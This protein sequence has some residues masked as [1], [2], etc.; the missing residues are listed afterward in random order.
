MGRAKSDDIKV[1]QA[2]TGR[3]RGNRETHPMPPTGKW[4][5]PL[6]VGFKGTRKGKPENR[7]FRG[8][9]L[10]KTPHMAFHELSCPFGVGPKFLPLPQNELDPMGF[11][12]KPANWPSTTRVP[13]TVG[14]FPRGVRPGRV[15]I[16]S[17]GHCKAN[18]SK[19]R[20]LKP[21]NRPIGFA[22]KVLLRNEKAR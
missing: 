2:T 16:G 13:T 12:K 18:S 21:P 10:K 22:L 8:S 15:W 6:L 20:R 5:P 4:R 9:N 14:H 11:D 19:L 17:P 3:F 1:V 7:P